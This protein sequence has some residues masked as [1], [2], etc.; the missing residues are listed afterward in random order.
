M[1]IYIGFCFSILA[2]KFCRSPVFLFSL[3]VTN[4]LTFS[5]VPLIHMLLFMPVL[6]NLDYYDF[7]VNLEIESYEPSQLCYSFDYS[8]S[9]A[10]LYEFEDQLFHFCRNN[11]WSFDS[12]LLTKHSWLGILAFF[13]IT[14]DHM[15]SLAVWC[16]Q[17]WCMVFIRNFI[18]REGFPHF[19]LICAQRTHDT[20]DLGHKDRTVRAPSIPFILWTENILYHWELCQ[21]ALPVLYCLL[22]D[23]FRVFS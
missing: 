15:T 20:S 1:K 11:N 16:K 12:P 17:K 18:S 9:L 10:I 4:F 13:A 8:G 5:S 7:V 6:L 14:C 3:V 22:V 21:I 23:F 19:I 2:L